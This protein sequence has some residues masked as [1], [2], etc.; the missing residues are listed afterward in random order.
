MEVLELA[1]DN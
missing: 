1:E